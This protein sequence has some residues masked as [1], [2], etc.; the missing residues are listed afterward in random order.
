MIQSPRSDDVPDLVKD[1]PHRTG[2]RG[3]V[4]ADDECVIADTPAKT[5]QA[6]IDVECAC[7]LYDA[8][9]RS[10]KLIGGWRHRRPSCKV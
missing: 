6:V 7:W 4:Q 10:A 3:K 2:C 5:V 1:Q 9:V 8:A